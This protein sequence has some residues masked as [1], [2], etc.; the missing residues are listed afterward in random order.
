[1]SNTTNNTTNNMTTQ[2][3]K[4]DLKLENKTE[5][6][7][8]VMTDHMDGFINYMINGVDASKENMKWAIDF[9][10]NTVGVEPFK[11]NNRTQEGLQNLIAVSVIATVLR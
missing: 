10:I 2:L 11:I 1:M 3:T 9:V 5:A 8:F 4:N 7:K 6:L